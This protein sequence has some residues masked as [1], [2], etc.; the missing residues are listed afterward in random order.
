[1][2][3]KVIKYLF[4]ALAVGLISAPCTAKADQ[5]AKPVLISAQLPQETVKPMAISAQLPQG[6]II[7]V[8]STDGILKSIYEE[9]NFIFIEVE[10]NDGQSH[11]FYTAKSEVENNKVKNLKVNRYVN[12]KYALGTPQKSGDKMAMP[13]NDI[14]QVMPLNEANNYNNI[15]CNKK[16]APDK[17]W[18][19]SFTKDIN[20]K[21]INNSNVYVK[22]LDGN[23]IPVNTVVCEKKSIKI[24][25]I[26]SYKSG[27]TYCLFIT[28]KIDRGFK[29]SVMQFQI[30]D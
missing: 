4:M 6:I 22:D 10:G 15:Q 24:T 21:N 18:V 11:L 19:V 28:N 13:L 16:V 3:K 20:E 26:I 30:E 23:N 1:M 25:P 12:V 8:D 5:L 29:G 9:N 2:N 14:N 17:E 27:E 7:G